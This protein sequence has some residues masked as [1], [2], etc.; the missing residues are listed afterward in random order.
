[1]DPYRITESIWIGN[2]QIYLR[3]LEVKSIYKCTIIYL[4]GLV[5]YL[6]F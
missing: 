5:Q 2:S 6:R 3:N 4:L 1:V